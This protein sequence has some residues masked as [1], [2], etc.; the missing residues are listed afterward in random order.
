MK[1]R[2]DQIEGVRPEQQKPGNRVKQPQQEFGDLLNE[3]LSRVDQPRQTQG[4]TPPPI[5]NPLLQAQATEKVTKVGTSGE[6]AV[7]QMEKLLDSWDSYTQKLGSAGL[8]EA[9]GELEGI[10][11]QV[12]RLKEQYPDMAERNPGLNEVVNDLDALA[13]A[14]KFKFNRGDYL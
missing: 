9:Y 1:I 11:G 5:V 4:L 8:K 6:E 10:S 13:T 2:P 3:E 7:G 12:S 14:E